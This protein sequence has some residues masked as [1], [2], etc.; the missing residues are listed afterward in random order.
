M[1]VEKDGMEYKSKLKVGLDSNLPRK[2]PLEGYY[3]VL[4]ESKKGR[5]CRQVLSRQIKKKGLP[6]SD[7]LRVHL[8]SRLETV[9]IYI[10]FA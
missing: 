7:G 8:S 5:S 3:R 6:D 9:I 1:H 2:K 10:L 4:T